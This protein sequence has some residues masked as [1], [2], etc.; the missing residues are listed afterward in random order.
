MLVFSFFLHKKHFYIHVRKRRDSVRIKEQ[1][2]FMILDNEKCYIAAQSRDARFDGVF[3]TAVTSTGIYCRPVCPAKTPRKQNCRFF[4][5]AAAAESAGFRPCLRCRP[6]L[7]PHSQDDKSRDVVRRALARIQSGE[8]GENRLGELAA[9]FNLS[10]RQL[11]RLFVQEFGLPPVAFAQTQKLLFAKKLLQETPLSMIDVAFSAGFGSVRRF[12]TLFR[13][14]Y[15]MAPGD[16][17]RAQSVSPAAETMALRL[18]YRPP[19]AWQ[20]ILEFIDAHAITGVEAVIGKA[21]VRS[22]QIE[23]HIGWVKVE[24]AAQDNHLIVTLP[25]ALTPVLMKVLARIK[26]LFDLDANP[27][28]IAE[29]F[30]TDARMALLTE[31][32]KGLRVPGAWDGF[33]V[34]MRTILGQQISVRGANTLAARLATKFSQSV[35]TPYEEIWLLSPNAKTLAA[36]LPE[37]IASVGLTQKRAATLHRLACEVAVGVINLEAS[38]DPFATIT[39]LKALPGI[40]DWTAQYIAMRA[41]H[42]PD[43]FPAGDLALRKLAVKDQMLSEN[44]LLAVSEQWRPWRA[45]AA[46]YLWVTLA[47][48]DE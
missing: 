48:K 43:A 5:T 46:M 17:R 40:G 29:Q 10:E 42:W 27:Q 44:Q 16:I 28:I 20:Q 19:F 37:D 26:H 24:C 1:N 9:E 8:L 25:T 34:A 18:A 36:A 3:F 12:N 35:E 14:R 41:L 22:L 13:E 4:P 32:V 45:Y 15:G 7:S 23:K 39:A 2:N 21:Y 38:A 6:E 11:R 31:K 30:A 47:M 33:E